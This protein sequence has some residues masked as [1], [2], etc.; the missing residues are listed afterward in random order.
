MN[1]EID[2]QAAVP[3]NEDENQPPLTKDPSDDRIELGE[4]EQP[5]DAEDDLYTVAAESEDLDP[6]PD[7]SPDPAD[8][9]GELERELARVKEELKARISEENRIDAD[10]L[11]FSTLYPSVALESLP[12]EVWESVGKKI[13]LAAAYALAERRRQVR[14]ETAAQINRQNKQRSAGSVSGTENNYFSPTEVR[15]MSQAEVRRNYSKIVE[16]MQKWNR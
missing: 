10:Y 16:S 13:P 5:L 6:V 1:E 8:R 11:E 7:T 2:V 4:L 9:I 14:E 12:D 3:E 15:A